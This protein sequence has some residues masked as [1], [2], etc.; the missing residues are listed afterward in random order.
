[1]GASWCRLTAVANVV[2]CNPNDGTRNLPP[3]RDEIASCLPYL[4]REVALVA[5]R[6]VVALGR[7][8]ERTLRANFADHEIRSV[9]HPAY[10]VRHARG[11]GE[12]NFVADLRRALG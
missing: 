5:L 1:M 2:K 4:R 3:S 6:R 11:Y 10:A 8:A 9:R 12:A 7:I